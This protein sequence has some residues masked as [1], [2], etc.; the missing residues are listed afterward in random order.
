MSYPSCQPRPGLTFK[1]DKLEHVRSWTLLTNH[2]R[3]LVC[4]AQD[5]QTRLRDI[6]QCADLTERATH[7]IVTELCEAGYVTRHKL[8]AR[9]FYEIH[10]AAPL[11]DPLTGEPE[12]GELLRLLLK[13]RPEESQ[14]PA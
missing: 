6:A 4:I 8:G 13:A 5:P 12:V 7:R 3:V 1:P 14:A 10:P 9:N 11:R 2:T